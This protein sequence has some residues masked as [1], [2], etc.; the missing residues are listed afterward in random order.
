MGRGAGVAVRSLRVDGSVIARR[1]IK[2][3]VAIQES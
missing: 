3:D 2:A 1:P